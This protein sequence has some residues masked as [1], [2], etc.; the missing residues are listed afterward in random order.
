MS[1]PIGSYPIRWMKHST[2][3]SSLPT[4]SV[5]AFVANGVVAN[6]VVANTVVGMSYFGQHRE[7]LEQEER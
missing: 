7:P 3:S 2:Y 5:N 4:A 1:G 6:T